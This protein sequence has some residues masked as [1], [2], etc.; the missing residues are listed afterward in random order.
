MPR[1]LRTSKVFHTWCVLNWNI[2][3]LNAVDKWPHVYS[4]IE[5]CAA[6]IVCLQETK[7]SEI[8]MNFIKNIAPRRLDQFAFV[9]A[10]G[11]SGG[12]L[13][14]WAS[15][16][17]SAQVLLQECFGLVIN[18]KSKLSSDTFTLVNVYGPCEGIAREN[19]IAW[20]FHLDIPDDSLWLIVGDFN[21][22]RYSD[23][24]NRSGANVT[25]MATFNEVISYLGLIE[26][27]IKGRNYTWSNMQEDAILEQIDWFFTSSAWTLKYPNTLVN[28]LARPTSDHIPCVIS[29]DT[30]I[31]KSQIFCFEHRWFRLPGFM[32]V[33]QRIW[34]I[35]CPGDSAKI[36]SAKFKLLRKGLKKWS[37][38]IS[39][40]NKII[41]NCNN[42]ILMLDEYEEKRTL[43]ITEWNFRSIVK[44][45]LHHLLC[46]KRDYW[47]KWCTAKWAQF[48]NENTSYFHSMATIR[49]RNNTIRSL[50]R[51]DGSIAIEHQEKAGILWQSFR[52]RLG[53]STPIDENFNFSD[54]IHP[55]E[56]LENLSAPFT[57][58]EIDKLVSELPSDKAPGPD[59]FTGLFM[60]KC[61]P[62]IKFDFYRLCDEF[63]EGKVNLQSINDAF[64]TLNP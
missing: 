24:R 35:S 31:P 6:S 22:Y 62:I 53:F 17:F 18:F 8:D 32:E 55:A 19:F 56:N 13:V 54:Y 42:I 45:K 49:Y 10:D 16:T 60:K 15:N 58:E 12:L 38:S 5:E 59:G 47:K 57:H 25:G 36:I 9:P 37:T 1:A 7:K 48:R 33:V 43:H 3:G 21:F 51:E 4:K 39:V 46:C 64:I 11:A 44:A 23:N 27:P 40:I 29:V 61:W 41:D 50:S 63:W 26:L 14:I 52:D 30:S 2:R 34:D 20:L 28:P